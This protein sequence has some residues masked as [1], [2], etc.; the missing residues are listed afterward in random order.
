VSYEFCQERERQEQAHIFTKSFHHQKWWRVVIITR[1]GA[2]TA[3]ELARVILAL[4]AEIKE[5]VG[6]R[7][8]QCK[9]PLHRV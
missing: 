7:M 8:A 5:H 2:D 9:E 6:L 3:L 1:V 4:G